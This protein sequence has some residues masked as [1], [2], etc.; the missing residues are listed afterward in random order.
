[1]ELDDIKDSNLNLMMIVVI[2]LQFLHAIL[3][4]VISL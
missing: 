3:F 2:S 1:M 4:I